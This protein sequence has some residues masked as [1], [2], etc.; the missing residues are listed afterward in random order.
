MQGSYSASLRTMS[1]FHFFSMGPCLPCA[2][3]MSLVSCATPKTLQEGYSLQASENDGAAASAV[4]E[5]MASAKAVDAMFLGKCAFIFDLLFVNVF[6]K[7]F[8][9]SGKAC[10][11]SFTTGAASVFAPRPMRLSNS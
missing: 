9:H 4:V 8:N 7:V 6:D 11:F 1:T 2:P 10:P 3:S 5:V